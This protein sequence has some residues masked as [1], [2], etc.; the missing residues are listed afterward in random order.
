M[1]RGG[2]GAAGGRGAANAGPRARRGRP[3]DDAFD[4]RILEAALD[5]LAAR[6]ISH[7]SVSAVARRAGVSKGSIYLRWPDRE[8]LML[9]AVGSSISRIAQPQPGSFRSQIAELIN[10]FAALLSE[11]RAA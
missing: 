2:S 11:P 3:R 8:E 1:T 9:D 4:G 5:E 10:D 7:F 6:G